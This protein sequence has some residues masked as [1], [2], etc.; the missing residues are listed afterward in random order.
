MKKPAR[1]ERRRMAVTTVLGLLATLLVAPL[2]ATS[3][4]LPAVAST[5]FDCTSV[6]SVRAPSPNNYLMEVD[7]DSGVATNVGKF[8]NS[9]STTNLNALGFTGDGRRAI[10]AGQTGTYLL[11]M[12]PDG[13]TTA[14]V[15]GLPNA[16]VNITH[17]AVNTAT[18]VYYYGGFSGSTAS[19]YGYDLGADEYLGLVA[20]GSVPGGNNGDWAFDSTGYLYVIAGAN[21]GNTLSVVKQ[22]LPTTSQ[23][24]PRTITGETL[25]TINTP[26]NNI[27]GIAFGGDGYLYM[28]SGTTWY[29]ANP[30]TGQVISQRALTGDNRNDSGDLGSCASPNT[31]SVRKAFPEGRVDAADQVTLEVTGGGITRGNRATTSGSK[32]GVQDD[33]AMIAG[34]VIGLGGETYRIAES[35]AGADE[36]YVRSW[37]CVDTNSNRELARGAGTSGEFVL[38][39]GSAVVCTFTNDAQRPSVGLTKTAGTP[40]DVNGNGITDAGDTIAYEFRVENTGNT[41]LTDPTVDDPKL[42]AVTCPAVTLDPGESVSCTAPVYTITADDEDDGAADNTATA[43]ATPPNGL[44]KV[45]SRPS[46][47]STP[48]ERAAPALVIEKSAEPQDAASYQ[49]GQEITYSFVVRNTG[50]VTVT[51]VEV[52]ESDF[53]GTGTLSALSCPDDRTL[54]PNTSL[55]CTATY[56]LTQADVDAGQVTN[57]ATAAGDAPDGSR[58]DSPEDTA[59]VPVDADPQIALEKSVTPSAPAGPGETVTYEFVITNTGNVSLT[60]PTIDETAFGG[61]GAPPVVDCPSGV[62]RPG[63]IVICTASY[64]ITDADADAGGFENTATASATPPAG[65]DPPVSAPSTARVNITARPDLD[66]S[67]TAS[68]D[69]IARAGDTVTYSFEVT[70]R[71]NVTISDIEVAEGSFSG[72]GE[73]GPIDCPATSL[74]SGETMTCT[75]TY[76]VTQEDVDAGTISNTATVGGTSP[77]GDAVS[78]P[79]STATV[80][81]PPN[82][83]VELEKRADPTTASTAGATIQYDFVVRNTGNVTLHGLAIDENEFSGTGQLSA[84]TCPGDTLAPG[85]EMTCHADYR[86]TQDDVDAGTVTNTAT[87]RGSSPANDEASS[88]PA[89]ATVTI[90]AEPGLTLVKSADRSELRVGEEI[91]YTFVIENTGNVTL[92]DVTV[93]D[94]GFTGSGSL[95]AISCPDEAAALTPGAQIECTASYTVTQADVDRGTIDNTATATGTAPTGGEVTTSP[96]E[97]RIPQDPQPSLTLAKSV[98]PGTAAEAGTTVTYTF[99]VRNTGNVTLHEVGIDELEFSGSGSLS[100]IGCPDG[101][102]A[103]GA[104]AVCTATYTITQADADAGTITNTASAHGAPPNGGTVDSEP[105]DAEVTIP[106]APSLEIV[107]SADTAELVAGET[108]TYSFVISNT[109]NVTLHDVAV[110]EGDFSG[111]GELSEVVCQNDAAQL[112]PGTQLVCHATYVVQQADVDR[113]TLENTASALGTSP[114]GRAVESDPSDVRIPQDPEPG[115]TLVKTADTDRATKAGQRITYSFAITNTG[116]VTLRDV[117]VQESEFS[118][119]GVLGEPTCPE[120]AAALLPGRTVVCTAVYTVVEADLSGAP[121]TNTAVASGIGPGSSDPVI[122]EFSTAEVPTATAESPGL[123]ITGVSIGAGFIAL[124]VLLVLGGASVLILRA[125]RTDRLRA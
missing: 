120:E 61:T 48:V 86:L 84:I 117:S 100:E 101:P 55:V 8:D 90:E 47:T 79:P 93:N 12:D 36:R 85:A 119:A 59:R 83:A 22:Q 123:A 98:D 77:T 97:V 4:A 23:P 27:N 9:G 121:L 1:R 82:P 34:P 30:S 124:A 56:T 108:I 33:P 70:N 125:R 80:D 20:R 118:G 15:R 41:I 5:T 95:S 122:S 38:P 88:S 6:Y 114:D 16:A 26:N 24:Q 52:T 49:E 21:G 67:K 89:N 91:T 29:Q 28:A 31:I 54:A 74:A 81:A 46:S 109:G 69:V 113:G 57:S 51:D 40:T 10:A 78:S 87:A 63:E 44:P 32:Q 7:P 3:D 43:G 14:L 11:T 110:S 71:G 72:T 112:A 94:T 107:K 99:T 50:N 104:T 65:A 45:S 35:G 92:T 18:N 115:L 42:G 19:I 68:P 106:P 76:Q 39:S 102:L 58:V 17:G 25:T 66:L 111:A 62:L 53:S 116:N 64:V 13:T 96:S 75:A 60:D 103:P 73:L 105:S 2:S 37:R